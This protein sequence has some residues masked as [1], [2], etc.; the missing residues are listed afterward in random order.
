MSEQ[1][2]D[3]GFSFGKAALALV[4]LVLVL[5]IPII[6]PFLGWAIGLAFSVFVGGY[7]VEYLVKYWGGKAMGFVVPS[8]VYLIGG[9]FFASIAI[10][11]AILTWLIFDKQTLKEVLN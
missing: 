11:I 3:K 4:A 5:Q 9:F 10:P 8:W 2:D 7:A 6:G 1:K